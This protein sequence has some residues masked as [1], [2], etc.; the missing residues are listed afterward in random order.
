MLLHTSWTALFNSLTT[1]N[2]SGNRN[3]AGF[4]GAMDFQTNSNEKM[5]QLN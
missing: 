3:I 2:G 1:V 4:T 5:T